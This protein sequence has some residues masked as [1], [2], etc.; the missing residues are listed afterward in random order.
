MTR[1]TIYVSRNQYRFVYKEMNP[2]FL[3]NKQDNGTGKSERIP[4]KFCKS[5]KISI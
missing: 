1:L 3:L 2:R 5:I 4:E